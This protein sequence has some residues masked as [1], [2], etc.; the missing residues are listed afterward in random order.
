M[1]IFGNLAFSGN[2]TSAILAT[3]TKN[4]FITFL[5]MFSWYKSLLQKTAILDYIDLYMCGDCSIRVYLS[6]IIYCANYAG[7]IG[8]CLHQ[9]S[10]SISIFNKLN[11]TKRYQTIPNNTIRLGPIP[12]LVSVWVHHA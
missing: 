1:S 9:V 4:A 5:K 7:I 2:K 11:D 6:F 3:E 12:I 10:V 8:G